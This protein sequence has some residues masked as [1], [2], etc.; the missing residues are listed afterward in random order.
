MKSMKKTAF[1]RCLMTKDVVF[2]G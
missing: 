1:L 2:V